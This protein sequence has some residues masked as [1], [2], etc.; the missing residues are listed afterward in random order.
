VLQQ[1]GG[2][3]EL[4]LDQGETKGT[5]PSTVLDLTREPARLVR[6]GSISAEQLSLYLSS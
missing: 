2:K 4:V 5:A 6:E 3:I 1:L